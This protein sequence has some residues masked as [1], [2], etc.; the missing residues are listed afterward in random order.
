MSEINPWDLVRANCIV[1]RSSLRGNDLVSLFFL[2]TA[3]IVGVCLFATV[4]F[5]R[6]N[7]FG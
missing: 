3:V 5:R 7:Y 4:I 2:E 6:K 1:I